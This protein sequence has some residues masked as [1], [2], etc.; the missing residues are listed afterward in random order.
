MTDL[1]FA[2]FGV[3]TALL[4]LTGCLFEPE[5]E[6]EWTRLD[7]LAPESGGAPLPDTLDA[8]D[9]HGRITYRAIRTGDLIVQIRVS[10][11]VGYDDVRLDPEAPRE[12]LLHDIER[13]LAGSVAVASTSV[14][15]TGW[16]RLIREVRFTLPLSGRLQHGPEGGVFLVFYLG[17]AEEMENPDGSETTVFEAVDFTELEILP[18]GLELR[19]EGAPPA[20]AGVQRSVDAAR[21]EPA[22][23]A[24]AEVRPPRPSRN[25]T[26]SAGGAPARGW[27]P[28]L[29]LGGGAVFSDP[30]LVD[31]QWSAD[32]SALSSGEVGV[33]HAAWRTGVR[34][35]RWSSV[36][37]VTGADPDRIQV[38][39]TAWQLALRRR[40]LGSERLGLSAGLAAGAL[41]LSYSPDRARLGLSGDGGD[42][43]FSPIWSLLTGFELGLHGAVGSSVQLAV[44]G[45][46]QFFALDAAHRRGPDIVTSEETFGAWHCRGRL[47]WTGGGLGS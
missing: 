33:R 15:A 44:D 42:V 22:E 47:I 10:D 27:Q 35:S 29:S 3:V 23:A 20:P 28:T 2:L 8:L 43:R 31:Y 19:T 45:G 41:R 30:H 1:R 6:D 9:F 40:V 34:V 17:T 5:I 16:D 38:N 13:V 39:Q 25:A 4:T 32:P 11:T 37:A 18:V 7:I 14:L 24:G 26:M 36:Q 12:A 46:R 21:F